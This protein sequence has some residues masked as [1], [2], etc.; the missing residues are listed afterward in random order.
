MFRCCSAT[1]QGNLCN[2]RVSMEGTHCKWHT[3]LT[4]DDS[5]CAICMETMT[6]RNNR[7][8][9]CEHKFHKRCLKKWKNEG[10]RTCPLCREQFDLP[11]FNIT[12]TIEPTSRTETT[13][14][15]GTFDMSHTASNLIDNMGL[16]VD[17]MQQ[18]NTQMVFEAEDIANLQSVLSRVGLDLSGADLD[19]LIRRDT[20]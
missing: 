15:A 20:E 8:L 17:E 3:N 11:S 18:F 19:S 12:V 6:I 7:E 5:N 9:P 10:N 14:R 1:T 4:G 13:H 2:N 16:D